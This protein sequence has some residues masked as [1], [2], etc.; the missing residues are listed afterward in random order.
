MGIGSLYSL[1]I[2]LIL[3]FIYKKEKCILYF[4]KI[5]EKKIKANEK[6]Y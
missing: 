5:N 4:N 3:F 2:L 1:A 6:R